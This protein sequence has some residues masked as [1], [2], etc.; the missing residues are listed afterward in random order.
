[1]KDGH[2]QRLLLFTTLQL[3]VIFTPSRNWRIFTL[4]AVLLCEPIGWHS[5][6]GGVRL[7]SPEVGYGVQKGAAWDLSKCLF[8]DIK[9]QNFRAGRIME[10][11]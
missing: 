9:S 11:M 4:G 3:V 2:P 7:G 6:P 5:E 8:F 1:M 10:I